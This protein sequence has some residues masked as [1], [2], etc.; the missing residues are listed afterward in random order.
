MI[1]GQ[2][3]CCIDDSFPASVSVLYTALPKKGQVY[4]I[5]AVQVGVGLE[6][7]VE[8]EVCVYL[9]GLVNPKS[10]KAPFR[11]RGFKAERFRPLDEIKEQNRK[12]DEEL[13]KAYLAMD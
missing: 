11:E 9:V 12:D 3:V 8:G 5:R 13:T 1:V 4:V 2:K 6:P 10:L 7:R